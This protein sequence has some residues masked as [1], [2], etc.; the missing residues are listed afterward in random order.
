MKSFFKLKD[1][2]KYKYEKL[3]RDFQKTVREMNAEFK[4]KLKEKDTE[5]K[6]LKEEIR[7][8]KSYSKKEHRLKDLIVSRHENYSNILKRELVIAKNIIK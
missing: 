1:D 2:Y 8:M 5:I 4:A 6:K 7:D 3:N